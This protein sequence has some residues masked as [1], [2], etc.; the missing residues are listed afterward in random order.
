MSSAGE[1]AAWIEDR[2]LVLV[3]GRSAIPSAVEAIV[4]RSVEGSWWADADGSLTYQLLTDLEEKHPS[5]SDLTLA[6]GKR[7]LIGAALMPVAQAVAGEV[8]RRERVVTT[9]RPAARHLLDVLADGRAVRSENAGLS[10][11]EF[12]KARGALEA[13]LLARSTSVHTESGHHAA[14][15]ALFGG[16]GATATGSGD[17][18][19]GTLLEAALR[20]AV[21]AARSEVER[22]FRYVEPDKQR[23]LTAIDNLDARQLDGPGGIWLTFGA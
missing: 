21:V 1:L 11:P 9:L 20:S 16:D 5:I 3:S 19:L 12:R 10:S 15:V 13:G 14:V 7:T 4:G 2:G 8:G 18:A 23:R 6:E 17:L 22:W